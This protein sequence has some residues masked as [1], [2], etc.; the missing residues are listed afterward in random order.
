MPASTA[1]SSS[2]S[3]PSAQ[4]A[5]RVVEANEISASSSAK[6]CGSSWMP[7]TSERSSF[8]MSGAIADDLL[9]AGVAVARVVERDPRA[10]RPQ[11]VELAVERR[12]GR[13][14]LVLGEL[15][16]RSP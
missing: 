3:T 5:A 6:R 10:A 13:E 12:V 14:E 16:R 8:R 4:T 2:V 9:Q 15:D 1:R 11:R 7:S